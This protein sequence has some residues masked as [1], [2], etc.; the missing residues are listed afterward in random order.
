MKF[1]L[2]WLFLVG[3]IAASALLAEPPDYLSPDAIVAA[4]DGATLFVACATGNRVLRVDARHNQ[5]RDFIETPGP[6]TGLVLS[7]DGSRLYVTCAAPESQALLVDVSR[8]KIIG[9]I[10]VGHTAQAPVLSLDGSTLYVCNQFDNDV[11]VVDLAAKR[12]KGRIAVLRE[13]V[14]ADITRDGKYLL[15]ANHLSVD[16]SDSKYAA[17]A[18]SVIDLAAGRTVKE[19]VLPAGSEML[20]G[21]RVSPDGKYAAL[22]HIYCNYDLPTRRVDN[23]LMNANAM[24]IINLANLEPLRTFLL[25][26]PSRGAGN[27]WAVAWSADS[28]TLVVTHAGTQEASLIDFPALLAGLPNDAKTKY[29]TNASTSVLKFV[30]H[31]EDEELNDGLPFLIGARRRVKLPD[32]DLGPRAVVVSGQTIYTANYFSDTLSAIDLSA[33]KIPAL[34]I[35]LGVKKE[36][37]AV[38]KGEFYF[39]D[40][41]L[42][43]QSWQS[44]SSCHPG[45]GRVDGLNWDLASEGP[46]HPRNT[47]SLL[48]ADKT[49]PAA[50]LEN[51]GKGM[52]ATPKDAVRVAIKTLLFTNLS[53]D[54]AADMDQYLDSLKPVPSPRLLHGRLSPAAL[55]GAAV[56]S[57]VGCVRCHTPR[58]YTDRRWH[59]VGTGTRFDSSPEFRTPTLIEVWRTAPYL[60][61]GSAAT[62][63]DVLVTRHPESAHHREVSKLSNQEIDDLC[64]YV[65]SL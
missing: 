65:L 37:T 17:A 9:A 56:F 49:M 24:T 3:K 54:I 23:G 27:P 59:D 19:L 50:V 5:V 13:P 22:T 28:S 32:G 58:L 16:R 40:A 20:K 55:R 41:D 48:L 35:A 10:T 57:Q 42:C 64:A 8:W 18:V 30:P 36:M 45:D 43:F 60:H 15:V 51:D 29:L 61:N 63:R 7:P 31:Y 47:R 62:I 25:D 44:C 38:R 21:L 33:S 46:G 26:E 1:R 34:S 53:E 11:S 12:E 39:N 4:S 6:A 2:D 14:A 52:G